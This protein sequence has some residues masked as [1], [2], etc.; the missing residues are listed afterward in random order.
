M[1]NV[2]MVSGSRKYV[3]VLRKAIEG[4]EGKVVLV[5]VGGVI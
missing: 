4:N 1:H 2:F 5:K 3:R